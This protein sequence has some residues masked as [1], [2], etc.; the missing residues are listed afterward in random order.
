M[1][2]IQGL[3]TYY[4]PQRSALGSV[5]QLG[6]E[7]VLCNYYVFRMEDLPIWQLDAGGREL[8]F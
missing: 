4:S 6:A 3:R 1:A 5:A 7:R 2:L 8:Y